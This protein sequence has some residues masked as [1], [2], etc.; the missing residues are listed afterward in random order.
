[1]NAKLVSRVPT[2]LFKAG[3]GE[4]P[5]KNFPFGVEYQL[6]VTTFSNDSFKQ[7]E[8]FEFL[9]TFPFLLIEQFLYLINEYSDVFGLLDGHV[10]QNFVLDLVEVGQGGLRAARL[11]HQLYYI[12]STTATLVRHFKFNIL[13]SSLI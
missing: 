4:K 9:Q 12:C 3:Q 10:G 7:V 6:W 5:V 13:L 11:I 2:Y 8:S 1:M